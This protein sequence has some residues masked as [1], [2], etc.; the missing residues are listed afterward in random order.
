MAAE[1]LSIFF[2]ACEEDEVRRQ[3]A[4]VAAQQEIQELT[5]LLQQAQTAARK[6]EDV[7]QATADKIAQEN[8]VCA[9]T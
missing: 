6:A 5:E 7:L 8:D 1:S 9:V 2:Q 3:A 4:R